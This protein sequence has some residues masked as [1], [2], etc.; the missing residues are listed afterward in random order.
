VLQADGAGLMPSC[1]DPAAGAAGYVAIETVRGQSEQP[2]RRLRITAAR[3]DAG[4]VL[5][6]C[7]MRSFPGQAMAS[8]KVFAGTFRLTVE[9]DGTHRYEL[10]YDL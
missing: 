2:S 10:E 7:S 3:H 8:L 6:R 1:G 5:K 4:P 9:E